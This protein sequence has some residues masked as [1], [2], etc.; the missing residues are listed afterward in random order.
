MA[1]R[2][3]GLPP[4]AR[5]VEPVYIEEG[6]TIRNSTIG[7]NVSIGKGTVI[8][9]SM[10]T[11]VIVG[12]ETKITRSRLHDSLIGNGVIIDGFRGDLTVADHSELRAT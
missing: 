3:A 11:D 12:E 4:D 8:E 7:P 5:I 6:V 2:P 9:S 10:L 1:R